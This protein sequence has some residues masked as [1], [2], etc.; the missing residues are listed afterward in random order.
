MGWQ[1]TYGS[2]PPI[3]TPVFNDRPVQEEL[4]LYRVLRGGSWANDEGFATVSYRNFYAPDFRD[5]F[6]GFRVARE[7]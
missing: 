5:L 7:E 6:V 2:G 3:G 4:H 1:A